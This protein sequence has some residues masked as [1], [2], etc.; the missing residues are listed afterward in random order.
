MGSRINTQMKLNK[1]VLAQVTDMH[2]GAS[3]AKYRGIDVRQQFLNVLQRLAKKPLDLL[4]LSGDLAAV[5]GEPEAYAWI[6]QV[7]TTF[8]YP[9]VIMAGNHDHV[10]RMLSAFNLQNSDVSLRKLYFSRLI[11]GRRL[12]FLDS[13]SYRVTKQQLEWLSEQLVKSKIK[14][15]R[16]KNQEQVLLFIHHPPL[17]CECQFMDEHCALQNMDE[18]WQVL[19]QFPQIKHIFC[20]HYHAEKTVSKNGKFV[21][22][23]PSTA[24]QID[25][26]TADFSILHTKPG[27]R[28]IEWQGTQV[29]TYVE[30]L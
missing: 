12:L 23:T 17:K 3:N 4:V 16:A 22:L 2:I 29:Q 14:N 13:A 28:L 30:Y 26:E 8:P 21:H 19:E 15:P 18:V 1:L 5:E 25:T 6:R 9:Y 7:L 11:K 10:E 27:W 24:F 20:G